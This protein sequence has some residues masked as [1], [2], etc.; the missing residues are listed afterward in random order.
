M[1]GPLILA[2]VDDAAWV[3]FESG[4]RSEPR[5]FEHW[6]TWQRSRVAGAASDDPRLDEQ[7]L[8]GAPLRERVERLEAIAVVG[9]QILARATSLLAAHDFKLLVADGEGVIVAAAGGGSFADE[10]RRARLIAGA[11]WSEASRGTNAIG[12]ALAEQRSVVVAGRAHYARCYRDLVCHAAPIVDHEGQVVGVLD[13]TSVARHIEPAIT[14][15]V[16]AAAAALSD[17]LRLRAWSLAG[18]GVI[19]TLGRTLD[20]MNV[21]ALLLEPPGRI[22]RCNALARELLARGELE[23]DYAQLRAEALVP[24]PGGLVLERGRTR[25]RVQVEPVAGHVDPMLGL[26]GLLVIVEPIAKPARAARAEPR[27]RGSAREVDDD[28]FADIFGEDPQLRVALGRA[29]SVARSRIPVVVLAETGSGKE[30]VARAIH[31]ASARAAGPFVAVNCGSL[32]PSLLETELFGHAPGAFTGASPKGRA[33]LLHAASGGTLLLDEVAEMPSAMQAAL[34]RVLES[35]EVVRVGSTQAEQVDVRI[36]C[37]TCKD[38]Q[39]MVARG[40]FRNDLYYRLKGVILRLPPLRE[41]S[42][43]PALARHLLA[44]LA[45]REGLPAP[46]LAPE[47]EA[48]LVAYPWPGNVRELRSTLALALVLAGE[49]GRVELEHLELEPG[50]T[51]AKPRADSLESIEASAVERVL[52]EVAGNVSAAARRLG[53]ARSTLYRMMQ[54]HALGKG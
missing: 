48:R 17:L 3:A 7:V 34:L 49:R 28:P 40:E 45:R 16:G 32:A 9:E 44:D 15:I 22:A 5:H 30:L 25:L 8:G 41:R 52:V 11:C 35:G 4:R 54:R 24:T 31:R 6:R 21:P 27:P 18:A 46:E 51:V 47:V 43:V 1:S 14:A 37:A 23:L 13:A 12:T 53:V 39:A 50:E 33:G 10:A 26:L 36:V 19:Q 38:L 42:D 20:R 29:R 2:D